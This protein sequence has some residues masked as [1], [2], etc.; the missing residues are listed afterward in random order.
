MSER[1]L[2][3]TLAQLKNLQP[4]SLF[5]LS[6]AGVQRNSAQLAQL[7]AGCGKTER[8]ESAVLSLPQTSSHPSRS[9]MGQITHS[10]TAHSKHQKSGCSKSGAYAF[11]IIPCYWR[12]SVTSMQRGFNDISVTRSTPATLL[13][14]GTS[15][16]PV[17][18]SHCQLRVTCSRSDADTQGYRAPVA[19]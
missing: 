15:V 5:P 4:R 18:N 7:S 14:P 11:H 16:L 10:N 2:V 19:M 6:C 1:S 3:K 13:L 8:R 17:R 9:H 12:K